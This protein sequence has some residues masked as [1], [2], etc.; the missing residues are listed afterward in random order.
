MFETNLP[1]LTN[2][3]LV[4]QLVAQVE[5]TRNAWVA[6]PDFP[7]NTPENSPERHEYRVALAKW[8][9][10]HKNQEL[11]TAELSRRL[12]T[13]AVQPNRRRAQRRRNQNPNS[14]Y[15]RRA[16]GGRRAL[17]R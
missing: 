1:K 17:D 6:I 4:D 12:N 9:L 15:A 11:V 16:P 2:N 8:V 5:D 13:P 10:L 7:E 3:E 14:P